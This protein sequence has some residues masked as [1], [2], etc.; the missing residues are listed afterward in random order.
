MDQDTDPGLFGQGFRGSELC[1]LRR[2]CS[3]SSTGQTLSLGG[4]PDK[5]LAS[6]CDRRLRRAEIDHE[7]RRI[8][9]ARD[10][11]GLLP[12]DTDCPREYA[13]ESS[14]A[15]EFRDRCRVG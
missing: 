6:P 14:Y 7:P 1:K 13:L 5:A 8:L 3:D 4:L 12:L 9:K 10:A 15:D 11:E 2:D